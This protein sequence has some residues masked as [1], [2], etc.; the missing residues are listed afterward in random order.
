MIGEA[1]KTN[2]TVTTLYLEGEYDV[3]VCVCLRCVCLRE[4]GDMCVY[5]MMT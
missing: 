2:S 5:V 1:L 4:E 3:T